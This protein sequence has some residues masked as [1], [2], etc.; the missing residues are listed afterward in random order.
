MKSLF[1]SA[2]LSLGLLVLARS[3]T[4]PVIAY[5]P[6]NLVRLHVLAHSDSEEDQSLKLKVRDAMIQYGRQNLSRVLTKEDALR[7]IA[8]DRAVLE[9]AAR[10]RVRESGHSYPV[11]VEVENKAFPP[12]DYGGLSLPAGMYDS[13]TVTIGDGQGSNW[14]CVMFPPLCFVDAVAPEEETLKEMVSPVITTHRWRFAGIERLR[15]LVVGWP[16]ALEDMT[17]PR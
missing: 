1:A 13:V 11:S 6:G 9:E 2:L 4:S 15:D 10:H 3:A 5:N 7:I 16:S 17:F 12:R 14:W 8:R